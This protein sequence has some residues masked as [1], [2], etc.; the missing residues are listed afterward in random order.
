MVTR[1]I[2]QLVTLISTVVI[3]S[4]L[5]AETNWKILSASSTGSVISVDVASIKVSP[6]KTGRNFVVRQIWVRWDH[7]NDKTVSHRKSVEL[8]SVDCANDSSAIISYAEYNAD[9]TVKVSQNLD[10]YDFRY[11]PNAPDTIG[12]AIQ[13]FACGRRSLP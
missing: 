6:P 1:T 8:Y 4:T 7:S 11:K 12:L 2:L 10:D 3:P 13:E 5:R 9:T